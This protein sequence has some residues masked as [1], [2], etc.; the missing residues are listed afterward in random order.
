MGAWTSRGASSLCGCPCPLDR[1]L[2]RHPFRHRSRHLLPPPLHPPLRRPRCHQHRHLCHH[3]YHPA[4]HHHSYRPVSHQ[5]CHRHSRRLHCLHR[6]LC[7]LHRRSRG[8]RSLVPADDSRLGRSCQEA[9]PRC[10]LHPTAP[11]RCCAMALTASSSRIQ[12]EWCQRGI[13]PPTCRNRTAR[14]GARARR[15]QACCCQTRSAGGAMSPH[16]RRVPSQC[17]SPMASLAAVQTRSR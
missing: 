13:V 15:V 8:G 17:D 6:H 12:P 14:W 1:H 9:T 10:L 2:L 4:S 16:S 7:H 5:V 11:P 3:S